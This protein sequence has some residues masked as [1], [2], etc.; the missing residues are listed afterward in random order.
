M[1]IR[2]I[3]PRRWPVLAALGAPGAL[4]LLDPA[5]VSAVLPDV[6]HGLGVGIDEALWVLAGYLLAFASVLIVFGRLGA[7]VG[8]R[9]VFAGGVALWSLGSGLCAVADTTGALVGARVA[10]GAGAAALLPQAVALIAASLPARRRAGA[11]GAVTVAAGAG[12]GAGLVVAGLLLAGPGWRWV[13]ALN[14][15]VGVIAAVVAVRLVPRQPATGWPRFDLT[16]VVLGGGGLTVLVLGL[17]EGERH[18]WGAIGMFAL[19]GVLAS[20]F[21]LLVMFVLWERRQPQPLLPMDLLGDRDFAL[22]AAAALLSSGALAGAVL[23][24]VLQLRSALGVGALATGAVI[25]LPLLLGFA[26]AAALTGRLV[27]RAGGPVVLAAGLVAAAGGV[28]GVAYLP[29]DSWP[30]AAFAAPLLLVGA[31]T[32]LCTGPLATAAL[33]GVGPRRVAAAASALS[34]ARLVGALLGVTAVGAVLQNRLVAALN[35]AVMGR[36]AQLPEEARGPFIAGFDRAASSGFRLDGGS[37]GLAG[38]GG[39]DAATGLAGGLAGAG[40][41]AGSGPVGSAGQAGLAPDVAQRLDQLVRDAFGDA[42]LSAARPALVVAAA[43]LLAGAA[44]TPLLTRG[45][46]RRVAVT[47]SIDQPVERLPETERR[48]RSLRRS[49]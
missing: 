32:G 5:V 30:A 45:G 3:H 48:P 35:T 44:L 19:P 28:L 22:G 23:V 39:F 25:G 27:D 43:V 8:R 47:P 7:A 21:A 33:R 1:T 41:S 49:S 38:T 34:T 36:V 4:V 46:W 17:I 24:L 11:F 40:G 9:A 2:P 13:F 16:G 12:A 15:P 14:V 10:Q 29:A 37:G 26:A 20:G 42:L 18:G 31:G 6:Q